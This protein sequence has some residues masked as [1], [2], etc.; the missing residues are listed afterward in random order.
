MPKQ[1]SDEEALARLDRR[2]DALH[3]R[4][5]R[6]RAEVSDERL[7][8][9]LVSGVLGGLGL[10]WLADH[11]VGTSPFGLI[12]GGLGGAIASIVLVVWSASRMTSDQARPGAPADPAPLDDEEDV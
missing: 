12:V 8:A 7:V 9:E 3:A 6:K 11:F 2:V 10:G 4:T 1:P 5:T